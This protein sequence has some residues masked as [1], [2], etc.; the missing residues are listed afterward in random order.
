MKVIGLSDSDYICVVN[1]TELEK[2]TD[3]YFGKLEKLKVGSELDLG[4]GYN[5]ASRIEQTCKKMV[6]AVGEFNAC[7]GTLTRFARMVSE[8]GEKS[9]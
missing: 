9:A 2:L 3:K 1:H 8:H 6:D 5:F 7:Q 4:E